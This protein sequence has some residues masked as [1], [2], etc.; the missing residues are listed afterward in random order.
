MVLDEIYCTYERNN[1]PTRKMDPVRTTQNAQPPKMERKQH[2]K[3]LE[4][5]KYLLIICKYLLNS[6]KNYFELMLTETVIDGYFTK[7][8]FQ[9]SDFPFILFLQDVINK[10]S[11]SRSK[12]S[13]DNSDRGRVF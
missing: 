7:L 4:K 2:S 13:S 1:I 12:E 8:I 9:Y 5:V 11:L 6:K 3:M 10:S